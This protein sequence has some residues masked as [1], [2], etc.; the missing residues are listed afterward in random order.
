MIQCPQCKN[1][2]YIGAL[3][4]SECGARLVNENEQSTR[5]LDPKFS[6]EL[7][8]N[9]DYLEAYQVDRFS[10]KNEIAVSLQLLESREVIT[11]VGQDEYK[12][13]RQTEDQ[14]ISPDIDLTPHDAYQ[15][16]VSRLHALIAVGQEKVTITDLNSVN[17]TRLNGEKLPPNVSHPLET[18]DIIILGNLGFRAIVNS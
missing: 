10:E 1:E 5:T 18:G 9:S 12:L 14:S 7:K 6:E 2:D 13:G 11:L 4:C 16:G 8:L 15:N 3:F 17:G